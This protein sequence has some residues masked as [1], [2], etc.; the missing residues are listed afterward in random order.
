MANL[1]LLSIKVVDSVTIVAQFTEPLDSLINVANVEI[2]SNVPDVPDPKVLEVSVRGPELS[3]TLQP[4]TPYSNYFVTF[5]ST[6]LFKF[7]SVNGSFLFEDGATNVAMVLGAEDPADPV[8]DLLT[9]YLKDN[10]YSLENGSLIRDAINS[11]STVVSQALHDIGQLKNDNY[12]TITI[13][14]EA[15]TRGSGPF[16]RLNEEGAYE[17]I[18][19]GINPAGSTTSTSQSFTSFPSGPITLQTIMV[20]NEK[21]IAGTGDNTFDG[22][23]LTVDNRF[24]T[25]LKNV[26]IEYQDGSTGIYDI[27]VFGYQILEPRY[28]DKFASPLFTLNDNQF[29]LSDSILSTA[30]MLPKAGDLVLVDY[31][32]KDTG[33]V[34]D[35]TSVVVS[36]VLD[37]VREVTPPIKTQF[38]LN[39][40]PVITANDVIATIGSITF[41]DPNSV[42]PFSGTHPAFTKELPFK[43]DGLPA[44]PGEFA[45]DYTTG[46]IYVY[47]VTT[48]DGTGDYPPVATYKYRN[49][50][51]SRLDYT[52]DSDSEELVAN[53]SRNLIEQA[54]KISFTYEEALVPGVDY[55]PQIHTEI[56]D[57]RIQN[58][59][60]ATNIV[61]SL[62]S[63]ITNVFRIFN[64]TS[65]EIYKITRWNGNNIYFS[66]VNPPRILDQDRERV[67]F[68]DV[69]NELLLVNE[70]TVNEL[71]T[72]IFKILLSNNTIMSA[73][74]DAIGSSY[75]SSSTFSRTDIFITELYYD[76]Q[77]FSVDQNINRLL[78]GE[79]LIDYRN[80][81]IYIGVTHAQ[82][83]D[84]G[85]V[86]YKK[87][88]ISPQ[89]SH[90]ISVSEIY[91]SI[92]IVGGVNKR[93]QYVSI[94][95]G[96]I[97]PATFDVTDE[98]FL[99]GDTT[100]PY[101]VSDGT[102]LVSD[103]IKEVRNIFDHFDL[104][105]NVNPTNFGENTTVSANIITLDSTGVQKQ[106]TLIVQTGGILNATFI[107]NGIEIINVISAIRQSDKVDLW[108]TPGLISGYTITLNGASSQVSGDVVFV[109]YNVGLN[110]S[111]TPV[112]DYNRGDYFIDYSFLADEI[113]ISYEYGDNNLDFRQSDS[114]DEGTSY[115][116]SYKAGALRDALLKN[117]GTLVN[118]PILNSFDTSLPRENYRDALKAALQS[119]TKGPTIPAM[120]QI[121]SNITHI[122]P[123][124][125]E[126]AFQSWSL[127][128]S[129]LY[130]A[131]IKTTG[132]I[133]LLLGKFD[134]GAL[135]T[136]PGQTISFPISSNLRLEEGTLETWVIPE[137]DGLDN[138]A[139]LTFSLFKDGYV[140]DS[141]NIYIGADSHNPIY[142]ENNTFTLNRTDIQSPVGLPSS[143]FTKTGMFIY[144]DDIA[145]QWKVY[146]KDNL[147]SLNGYVY[148][149]TIRSS[150]EVYDVQFLPGLKEINDILRSATNKIDFE[151]HIDGYDTLNPDGY[152]D[153]YSSI[154]GYSPGAGYA[155]GY[156]YDGIRF[157]AD[158]KHYIFDFAKND[159]SNRF[160]IF[161]DGKGYLNFQVYGNNGNTNKQKHRYEVSTDISNWKAGQKHQVAVS[162]RLNSADRR[163]EMH[164][165]IDGLE[166]PN[167]L[168]FGGKPIATTSDRF[169][170][171]KPEIVAGIVPK[172]AIAGNDLITTVSS[173]VVTSSINNFQSLGIV[174]GDTIT[175]N[176]LGF[177]TY[178]ILTVNGFI[179][180][181][182]SPMPTTLS[183][184]RYSVNE[185]SVVVSSEIDLYNNVAVSVLSD[186]VE[187]EIPGLRA[188]IPE[189][190]ISNNALNQNVLTIL[191]DADVGDQIVIR[192]LGQNHR[193]CRDTQFIWGNTSNVLKSQLPPPINLDEVKITAVVLPLVLIGPSNATF[194]AGQFTAMLTPTQP[195]NSIEGRTLTVRVTGGNVKFSPMPVTVTINGTTAAG[196]TFEILTFSS[197]IS[198]TTVNK[199]KTITSAVVVTTPIVSTKNSVSVEIKEAN[200][201][202]VSEGNVNYPIIRFSFKIQ[203]G[204][205][206]TNIGMPVNT[207]H[208]DNGYFSQSN[209]GQQLVINSPGSVAGTYSITAWV[210]SNTV[211]VSP[212]LA[213][214]FS[215]GSYDIY[216]INISRSGFQN[217]FFIFE[218]AGGVNVPY[219]LPQGVYEFD[220][221]TYLEIP[222]SPVT[223]LTGFVGSDY[224]GRHQAKAVID[225]FRI[226]S[227]RL[228]DIRV[229][230][231]LA[232]NQQ[233]VTT[234]FTSL[235]PFESDSNTLMLLHFD[236]FPL[237]NSADVWVTA[238]KGF[239][240]SGDSVNANF[241]QSLVITNQ[242]LVV[243]NVGLLSTASEGSIEFWVSPRF[244]TY[245]DPN[246]RFYFDSTGTVV[247]ED[248]SITNG[249]VK[250]SGKISQV[251]SVRLQT[252]TFNTG[253]DYFSGGSI[254]SDFQT[255][256]LQRALP[257]QQT[258][259][260]INYI[261]SG[262]S[263]NRISIYKDKDGFIN[264]NVKANGFD[265][266][267]RQP[268]FW[269][270]DSWHRIQA[271]Y[272][273]NRADNQDELRLF[274]DGEENGTV[275][276]GQGLLFGQGVIFGQGFAGLGN[277]TLTTDI[278]FTD[279][280]NEF[281]IGSDYFQT[282]SANARI[283][284]FRLSNIA[285]RP[286]SVSGQPMDV[287]FSSN[288]STVFPVVTDAFTTYLLDFDSLI[289][290]ADDF[291]L[292]RDEK[293]GIFDF[294]LNI[295]DSFGIVSSNAKIKQVLE[296]LIATLKPANSRATINYI[297]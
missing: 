295:I 1:R 160:S 83:F 97:F 96:E 258:P 266:Q 114:V 255:I 172:K 122:D 185:Y 31:E 181:L 231:T 57:E 233:S 58:R 42:P 51:A 214:S 142:D 227:K 217:G 265:Y 174:P 63:P 144:Y 169:R 27:S 48:S 8:R 289:F 128:I 55:S 99:N 90:V 56:L 277:S 176:E 236:S 103:D 41:L 293:F 92:S 250:V 73:S 178:N 113:L 241:D 215:G 281:F 247:E 6:D 109:T 222:F 35:E 262:L 40:A 197:V 168:R 248:I 105:N 72:R 186:G 201:I 210:D 68:T 287:N 268:I 171:V 276:F 65:G 121:V 294:T 88:T 220:F 141:N 62:N 182:S 161:K 71:D 237:K 269:Q 124:I 39:H 22:L 288:L 59:L 245:N 189:Y 89:N 270:S 4:L 159:T 138:D 209:V 61:Q 140:L 263:G 32:Y 291:A 173:S 202:T 84:L 36:Q 218:K 196:P 275:V 125:I 242:P 67:T 211:M 152:V 81:I 149:G 53:P 101:L 143:I 130:P 50:F 226:L 2:S 82:D 179:L 183:D 192:T 16:D 153:G 261:P 37:A 44:Q 280:L 252:D 205:T 257:F 273:F 17:I 127:G 286:I 177:N 203:T 98:R 146:A 188:T 195:S 117:F 274:I 240:Q 193:R 162:W 132:D 184:A 139:T 118:I 112:V 49:S 54:A 100:L 155:M 151:F 292:L 120:M 13:T 133:Q 180:T 26:T 221:S 244:D 165:F 75:N 136:D 119:F 224:K 21:L 253:I 9:G 64:E 106:E 296:S 156:S 170:T 208:D 25:K 102:I 126:A 135:L 260:K 284:N 239:L 134:F 43:F 24:V 212:S 272:K 94:S 150:G 235:R 20:S 164:L 76:S 29:K 290:K 187:T 85:T 206:L 107:T 93:I 5:K 19:V 282:N 254:E 154:D 283:D 115:F 158:D 80:G 110:S 137:W 238:D 77:T 60:S 79:Y 190:S 225:E 34:V 7:K 38:S 108:A 78:A 95:E 175:I 69:S 74:E 251:L 45:V 230:E 163:D 207:V 145:K 234:D 167:I 264:F 243:D 256:K 204:T 147:W 228:T 200:P 232:N 229:G 70:D 199:F 278:N 15:K 213:S 191:G 52:Y 14:D 285:R 47:G 216:N 91:N 12:L 104:T 18:R 33:R 111:A 279:P 267:V 11:Q 86:N 198:Q 3:I 23:I 249:I 123:E 259:V 223:N 271:T 46:T 87:S 148:S 28:D 129:R 10:I 30:F 157:M 246:E 297:T 219:P 66:S 131:P 116:V 166:V 194:A